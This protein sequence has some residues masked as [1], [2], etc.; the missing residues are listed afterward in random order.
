MVD[1]KRI[2]TARQAGKSMALGAMYGSAGLAPLSKPHTIVEPDWSNPSHPFAFY[3]E[4]KQIGAIAGV[5][6]YQ[7]HNKNLTAMGQHAMRVPTVDNIWCCALEKAIYAV[8]PW[9]TDAEKPKYLPCGHAIL[10]RRSHRLC[11][12]EQGIAALLM[13]HDRVCVVR[14]FNQGEKL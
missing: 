2:F 3:S 11:D 12:I 5:H 7:T 1:L 10:W 14:S 13:L 9:K 6:T 8:R 4:F